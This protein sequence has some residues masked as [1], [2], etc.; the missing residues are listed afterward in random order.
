MLHILSLTTTYPLDDQDSQPRFIEYLNREFN[1]SADISV[2]SPAIAGRGGLEEL[3]DRYR[4]KRFRYMFSRF[5]SL[6]GGDGIL[7]N[8]KNNKWLYAIIPFFLLAFFLQII[9][10]LKTSKIDV[11]HAH[12]IIPQGLLAI[13][14]RKLCRA[15]VKIVVTSHGGDL[16]ALN[17]GIGKRLKGLVLNEADH[18]TVVSQAMKDYCCKE[19]NVFPEKVSV[20]SMGVDLKNRFV[21][22]G[23]KQKNRFVFVGRMAE[24]KGL[25]ILLEALSLSKYKDRI[26]LDV[27]GG[28]TNLGSYKKLA[29][30]LGISNQVHFHGAVENSKV[31][32]FYQNAE[33]A[34]FPFVIAKDGDQEGLGLTMVEAM[35]CKCLVIASDLGAIHDVVKDGDTGLLFESGNVDELCELIDKVLSGGVNISEMALNGHLFALQNFDWAS[36]GNKYHKLLLDVIRVDAR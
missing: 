15:K 34:V 29:D 25:S 22:F 36:I 17:S 18:I 13:Y 19:F 31:V 35:G 4:V 20:I 5:E 12:W 16:F 24:K 28:G 32:P 10:M 9:K 3:S 6:C 7:E 27:V 2:L 26:I 33:A 21:P 14:A 11:I 1:G 30:T 23:E 8:L